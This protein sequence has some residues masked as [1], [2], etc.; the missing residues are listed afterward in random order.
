MGNRLDGKVAIV[1]GS[2][3]GIG[4]EHAHLLASEG[5]KVLVND[6]GLRKTPDGVAANA[7]RVAGEINDAGGEAV[8]SGTSATW[9]G[10]AEIVQQAVDAFGRLDI[11]VNN[12]TAGRNNDI[13]RFTE[14]EWDLTVN[15]NLK[16]YFAMIKHAVPHLVQQDTSAIVNT[17]SGSGFGH[18]SHCAYSAAKEGVIGLTRTAARELGRFGVRCNAIRPRAEGASTAEYAI[19]TA[20]WTD[21]M[22]LTMAPRGDS[23]APAPDTSPEALAP[24]KIAPLVVWLCTDAARHVT[25]RTFHISGD[26]VSRLSEPERELAVYQEDG[27]TLDALDAYYGRHLT[28]DLTNDYLLEDRPDLRVFEL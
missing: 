1:T 28:E 26:I 9:D 4:R 2:G 8:A 19:R 21:L 17:S 5:A 11:L 18:P 6:L 24:R 25:G 3:G 10:A 20:R 23:S 15:V 7:E 27:L 14:E 13:W 16:G 22:A 12:A